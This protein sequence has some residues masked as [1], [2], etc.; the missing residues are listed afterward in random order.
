MG[1]RGVAFAGQDAGED[2]SGVEDGADD[3]RIV[4]MVKRN[5]WDTMRVKNAPPAI[6]MKK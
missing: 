4:E 6:T 5:E 3:I 2:E 1:G